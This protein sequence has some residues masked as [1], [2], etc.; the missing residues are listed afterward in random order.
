MTINNLRSMSKLDDETT[1][2]S[3]TM[4]SH[5]RLLRVQKLLFPIISF[6]W[7]KWC[8]A[9][10]FWK[11]KIFIKLLSVYKIVAGMANRVRTINIT[12][13]KR[14]IK[15][16]NSIKS[17]IY[18][19]STTMYFNTSGIQLFEGNMPVPPLKTHFTLCIKTFMWK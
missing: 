6:S 2:Y 8:L 10:S 17:S 12:K 9:Y 15:H 5:M 16:H 3:F 19:T 18:W 11:K 1:K 14:C 4:T 7:L 13:K